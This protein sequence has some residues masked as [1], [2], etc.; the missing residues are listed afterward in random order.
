M[1]V[2]FTYPYADQK[3][4]MRSGLLWL[5]AAVVTAHIAGLSFPFYGDGWVAFAAV[6]AIAVIAFCVGATQLVLAAVADS[7]K[8]PLVIGAGVAAVIGV[9]TA[10]LA[11]LLSLLLAIAHVALPLAVAALGVV[12]MVTR[13]RTDRARPWFS[14]AFGFV[15]ALGVLAIGLIDSLMLLPAKLV[16][17]VGID[18][19]YPQLAAAGED[20]GVWFP[21]VWAAMW[22]VAMAVLAVGVTLNRLP[23]R[24]ALGLLLAASV[25][26]LLALPAVQ[27]ALG[28]SI[29]D[30][31]ATG[32]GMSAAYPVINL[33]A[34]GLAVCAAALLTCGTRS[35]Q[36]S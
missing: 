5:G 2:A 20:G 22:A 30:T 36:R 3:P 14:A 1:A 6:A 10:P 35:G 24:A 13:R 12:L 18:Q 23:A 11:G 15:V 25:A 17:G 7:A 4:R 21:I 29:A 8:L 34:A 26:A 31:F 9:L 19:V 27:F 33:V 28:M 32:G 16:P